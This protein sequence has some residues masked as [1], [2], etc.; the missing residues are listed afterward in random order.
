MVNKTRIPGPYRVSEAAAALHERQF[1]ADLHCDAL[2]W[3]RNLLERATRGHVDVPRMIEGNMALQVFDAVTRIPAATN[4]HWTIDKGDLLTPLHALQRW[5]E[6][7]RKSTYGRAMYAAERLTTAAR[8]SDGQLSLILSRGDLATYAARREQNRG[9]AA[10]L[11]AIEGLHCLE[12]RPERVAEFFDAGFRMMAPVHFFDN[13]MGGSAHGTAKGGLTSFGRDVLQAM[14]ERGITLDLAH[15][16]PKLIDDVLEM[17]E[18]PLV[19]SH[20]GIKGHFDHIRNLTNEHAKAIAARGGLIGIGFWKM[21]VG[22][23]STEAILD[24][25]CYAVELVGAEHVALGS[26][27]DG[28][29]TAPFDASGLALLTEGLLGRGI[30]GEDIGKIMGENVLN[31]LLKALPE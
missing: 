18:R 12:G 19:V 29:V 23:C 5:P 15:A 16:A 25:L 26:D 13:E 10:G 24:G 22:Q 20:T 4:M 7:A 1:V 11:L 3:N 9:I 21:A 2:L 27:Y 14:V 31:L 17:D 8:E 28:F 30:G 6:R